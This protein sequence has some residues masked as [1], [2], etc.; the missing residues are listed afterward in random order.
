MM[1][2]WRPAEAS[3]RQSRQPT[4]TVTAPTALYARTYLRWSPMGYNRDRSGERQYMLGSNEHDLL[5]GRLYASALG[6]ASWAGTLQ[7][8]AGAFGIHTSLVTVRNRESQIVDFATY[9]IPQDFAANFFAGEVYNNDPRMKIIANV[10]PGSIYYDHG[11]YDIDEINRDP[12]SKACNDA[13][14]TKYS[15]G[16]VAALPDGSTGAFGLL[17]TEAQ[18]HASQSAIE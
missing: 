8:I 10:R 5:V 6:E 2:A 15:L 9:P 3:F 14:G 11:L 13:I 1:P 12:Y 17:S 4:R 18:G 7:D 16:A